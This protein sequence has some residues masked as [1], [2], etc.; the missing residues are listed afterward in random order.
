[1]QTI[2]MAAL[3]SIA[4][5]LA[6]P[7]GAQTGKIDAA[8]VE[9]ADALWSARWFYTENKKQTVLGQPYQPKQ[10]N[11]TLQR[12]LEDEV[13]AVAGHD[14]RVLDLPEVGGVTADTNGHV[15]RLGVGWRRD[16]QE[17]RYEVVAALAVSSNALKNLGDLG[18]ED[19][20]FAGAIEQRLGESW[21]VA[22]RADDRFGRFR[23]YPGFELFL[24]PTPAH[25]VRV[26]FPESSWR[27][28]WVP[29]L[30]S[31]VAVAPD[32]SRWRVRD[33]TLERHSIVRQS[34]WRATWSLRWQ[35]FDAFAV[36]ARVG[37]C[38]DSTLRYQLRDGTQA[39]VEP[40]DTSFFGI[41]V[42]AR[43]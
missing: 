4:I 33:P 30:Q 21:K 36:E 34:V 3:A 32:G 23:L 1:M 8:K 24:Q 14:Y 41:G 38:F 40:P 12:R 13:Y 16:T 37:W 19:L 17:Q 6:V 10:S 15:H 7:V 5:A 27:W 42:G 9:R 20:R 39:Q 43:F 18:A 11:F 2:A 31:E 26:G 25:E 28:Q 29:R 35:L 22:L